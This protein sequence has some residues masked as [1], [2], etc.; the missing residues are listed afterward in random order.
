MS[1]IYL[2]V[3][4]ETFSKL[5]IS[6]FKIF[7][8]DLFLGSSNSQRYHWLLR[9]PVAIQKSEDLE[10]GFSIIL[11]LKGIMRLIETLL[12]TKRNRKWKIPHTVLE[13]RTLYFRSYKNRKL[14]VKLWWVGA[15][16]RKMREFFVPFILS[17]GNFFEICVLSQCIVYWIHFQNIS[18]LT[19]EK[20]ILHTLLLLVFKIVESLQ[21][22]LKSNFRY[23]YMSD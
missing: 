8:P 18:T 5:P 2:K 16:E 4:G 22:I 14:K 15:R 17:E 7:S 3:T 13:R 12:K 1:N 21:S 23:F 20:T 9:L 11:I 6:G 10:Q 19:Y